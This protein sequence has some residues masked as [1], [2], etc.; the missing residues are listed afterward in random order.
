MRGHSPKSLERSDNVLKVTGQD[1]TSAISHVPAFEMQTNSNPKSDVMF[2]FYLMLPSSLQPFHVLFIPSL[3]PL[4][5]LDKHQARRNDSYGQ[6]E[7]SPITMYTFSDFQYAC[8]TSMALL[9]AW[10][11]HSSELTSPLCT[12]GRSCHV[13][14][15]VMYWNLNFWKH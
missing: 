8:H 6:R 1:F 9:C 11:P 3:H 12:A 2:S 14:E 13:L 10:I 7:S 4:L 15:F 5:F